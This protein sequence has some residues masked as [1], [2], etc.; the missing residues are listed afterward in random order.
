MEQF[1]IEI[2]HRRAHFGKYNLQSYY[3]C[4]LLLSIRDV[5][6][7]LAHER[8]ASR[9]L[10]IWLAWRDAVGIQL[11]DTYEQLVKIS[12][13]GDCKLIICKLT[14]YLGANLNGFKDA[15]AMWR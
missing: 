6:S 3:N 13:Q 2:V 10:H 1:V 14:C 4:F 9:L 8:D 7:M 15:G 5:Q 12:N 11:N